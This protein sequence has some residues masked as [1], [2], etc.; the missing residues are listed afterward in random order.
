MSVD[1][2]LICFCQFYFLTQ[3]DDFAKAIAFAWRPFLPRLKMVPFFEY[4]VLFKAV[5][6]I[7]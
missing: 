2:F 3:I 5:F 1:W 7:E 4:Q 6:C